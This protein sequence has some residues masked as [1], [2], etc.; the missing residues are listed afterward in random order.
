MMHWKLGASAAACLLAAACGGGGGGGDSGAPGAAVPA[1]NGAASAP[2]AM[3]VAATSVGN[4]VLVKLFNAADLPA[5]LAENRLVL[6]D[7]FGRRAIY[8]LQAPAGTDV[9]ALAQRLLADPRVQYAEPN[10]LQETPNG[11][12]GEQWAIGGDAGV[13]ATQ[14]NTRAL[15]LQE[16]HS[17]TQ[18]AGITVAVLD[19]GVDASHPAL[20][21]RL[22]PGFDFVDQD[23]VPNEQGGPRDRGFGHGTHVASLV[24]QVAPGARVMPIRVLDAQGRG[25]AWVLA[26]AL[27]YAVDPDG[28]PATNDGAQIINLSLGTTRASD[29]IES[30]LEAVTCNQDDDDRDQDDAIRCANA[31]GAVVVSAAGNSGDSTPFYPAAED[32][33]GA[34]A[35]A[36]ST[37]QGT[38]AGFSTR[39][40][41]VQLAAPGERIYG[42]IP[43]G[44][45]GVWSGT[46]MSAPMA[47]GAAALLR[48]RF[49]AFTPQQLANR[50]EER[51]RPL[52]GTPALRQ[53]DPMA[54]LT[55]TS[56]PAFVCP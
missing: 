27:L 22:A 49:P 16:A 42:A 32:E 30:I 20:A 21:G 15:R 33:D 19:T 52:C 50:L 2:A 53:I 47:A 26:E 37:E 11:Q 1:A 34:I 10:F 55:D 45:W 13:F 3:P 4:E 43:G 25:N 9:E 54:A 14:W 28:N 23:G 7:Q 44:N 40:E 18:G 36:A 5:V 8:R 24:L 46:S 29:V 41:W 35:V 12:R 6:V 39:G 51:A 31:G 48:A 17:V 56:S 38:L